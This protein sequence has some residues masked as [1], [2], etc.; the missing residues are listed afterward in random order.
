MWVLTLQ[1]EELVAQYKDLDIFGTIGPAAQDQQVEYEVDVTV[2][3]YDGPILAALRT[4]PLT[5]T[6]NACSA[7]RDRYSAPTRCRT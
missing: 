7:R 3:T 6:R 4:A 2:E 1:H 5:P